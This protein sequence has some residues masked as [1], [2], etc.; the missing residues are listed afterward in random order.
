LPRE[1][2]HTLP[3]TLLTISILAVILPVSSP[4]DLQRKLDL[5]RGCLMSNRHASVPHGSIPVKYNIIARG[6]AKIRAIEKLKNS[7]RN[8][9]LKVLKFLL[10]GLFLNNECRRLPGPVQPEYST[11]ATSRLGVLGKA[12]LSSLICIRVPGF[13]AELPPAHLGGPEV[14]GSVLLRPRKSPSR[15]GVKGT[16]PCVKIPPHSNRSTA[17]QEA[18]KLPVE[19][20]YSSHK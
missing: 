15:S 14:E 7:V 13:T 12:K 19:S 18:P 20:G 11:R 9:T 2:H 16:P 3:W 17:T 1:I 6:R 10:I 5:P 4:N 8:C